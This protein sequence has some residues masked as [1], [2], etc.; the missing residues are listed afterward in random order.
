MDDK[1]NSNPHA[2]NRE[3]SIQCV[4]VLV[5]RTSVVKNLQ[6]TLSVYSLENN[7]VSAN[8]AVHNCDVYHFM[9]FDWKRTIRQLLED[10]K[11]A[12][13]VVQYFSPET[14]HAG[15]EHRLSFNESDMI[16]DLHEMEETA[17]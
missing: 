2:A 16:S 15:L 17:I 9:N 1:K 13:K 5:S 10:H 4:E 7:P 12:Y 3:S 14:I 6:W 8:P 11:I